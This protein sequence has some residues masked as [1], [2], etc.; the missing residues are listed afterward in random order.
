MDIV[1]VCDSGVVFELRKA[2]FR[3]QFGGQE[4]D[5]RRDGDTRNGGKV[6]PETYGSAVSWF[7]E[8][9][10]ILLGQSK[11]ILIQCRFNAH[12]RSGSWSD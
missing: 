6:E 3:V 10:N 5:D 2:E 7:F 11:R 1:F 4:G 8:C 12:Y 9:A